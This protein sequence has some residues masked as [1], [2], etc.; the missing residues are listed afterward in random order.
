MECETL[1]GSEPA[2]WRFCGLDAAL[3]IAAFLVNYRAARAYEQVEVRWSEVVLRQV[4]SNGRTREYRF[5]PAW[6]RLEVDRL[7]DEGVVRIAF[8]SHGRG[9][10]LAR[11]LNPDDR[12]SFAEA[13]KRALSHARSGWS[14]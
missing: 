7:D 9:V 10:E 5:N 6:V 4:A 11:F 12:T 14:D 13:L 2:S 8:R 1:R 3:L